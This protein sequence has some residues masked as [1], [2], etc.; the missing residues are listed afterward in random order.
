MTDQPQRLSSEEIAALKFAAHRQLARWSN[1]PHL[2][3][4]QH[5]QR[6][7]LKRAVHTLQDNTFAGGCELRAPR[8]ER[9]IDA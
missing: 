5:A 8:E 9:H 6:N 7:A 1:K 2:S 3:T 4:R